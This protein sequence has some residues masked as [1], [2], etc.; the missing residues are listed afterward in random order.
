M[1]NPFFKKM[2]FFSETQ[3]NMTLTD[4]TTAEFSNGSPGLQD[5]FDPPPPV[6]SIFFSEMTADRSFGSISEIQFHQYFFGNDSHPSPQKKGRFSKVPVFNHMSGNN[7]SGN[8]SSL[9]PGIGLDTH[10]LRHFYAQIST[11]CPHFSPL[12]VAKCPLLC[13]NQP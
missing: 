13:Y 6:P 9:A 8:V 1:S 5:F 7:K 10:S 11:K 4:F 2:A 12:G 3:D